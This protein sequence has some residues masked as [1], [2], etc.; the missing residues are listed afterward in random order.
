M[1]IIYINNLIL[2]PILKEYINQF[3]KNRIF[4]YKNQFYFNLNYESSK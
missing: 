4:N 1:N 3:D 2:F